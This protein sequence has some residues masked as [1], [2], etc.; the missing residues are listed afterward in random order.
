MERGTPSTL[1]KVSWR[2]VMRLSWAWGRVRGEG[3]P[4][5]GMLPS[6]ARLSGGLVLW[7]TG[8]EQ[9]RR[10]LMEAWHSR[11][12]AFALDLC[13]HAGAEAVAFHLCPALQGRKG[14]SANALRTLQ[15]L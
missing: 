2:G 15:S 3:A 4:L 8:R 10:M 7:W 5:G 11:K 6:S 9:V 1:Y 13:T 12:S 14:A